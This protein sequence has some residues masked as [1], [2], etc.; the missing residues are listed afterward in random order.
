MSTTNCHAYSVFV[1]GVGLMIASN[2]WMTE[3]EDL[4]R[5]GDRD[6]LMANS[7]LMKVDSPLWIEEDDA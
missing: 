2:T 5:Q 7:V 4:Q 1:S 6:W 3:L